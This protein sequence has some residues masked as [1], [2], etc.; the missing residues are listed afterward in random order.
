M[1][2]SRSWSTR[3]SSKT[4][5]V[6]QLPLS[7]A[8]PALLTLTWRNGVAGCELLCHVSSAGVFTLSAIFWTPV[9]LV[10][11][12]AVSVLVN[13]LVHKRMRFATWSGIGVACLVSYTVLLTAFVLVADPFHLFGLDYVALA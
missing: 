9:L 7:F 8:G 1:N 4:I 3:R 12:V 10:A 6:A 5:V 13:V 2:D 11:G